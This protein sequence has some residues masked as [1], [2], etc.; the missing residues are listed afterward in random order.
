MLLND[1]YWDP[2]IMPRLYQ[3]CCQN[4][5]LINTTTIIANQ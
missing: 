5:E 3:H 4:I 2:L 1:I